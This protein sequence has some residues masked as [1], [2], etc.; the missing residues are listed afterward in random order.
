L[1]PG[2]FV[3]YQEKIYEV[4][5]RSDYSAWNRTMSEPSYDINGNPQCRTVTKPY[6][7]PDGHVP[8][9]GMDV[10]AEDSKD[11]TAKTRWMEGPLNAMEVIAWASR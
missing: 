10:E 11:I 2:Q 6:F 7:I 5:A 9:R 1:T 3:L 8:L 4:L